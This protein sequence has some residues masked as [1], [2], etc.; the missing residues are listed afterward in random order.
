[1]ALFLSLLEPFGASAQFVSLS[2]AK[3]NVRIVNLSQQNGVTFTVLNPR[4][5]CL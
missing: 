5:M 4:T 2:W 3:T 1:M